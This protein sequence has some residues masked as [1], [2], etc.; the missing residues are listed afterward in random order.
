MHIQVFGSS[1]AGNCVRIYTDDNAG[2][3]IDAGIR[4]KDILAAGAPLANAS[5]L[6]THE[7]GDHSAHIKDL[8]DKYGCMIFATKETIEQVERT[9]SCKIAGRKKV[10]V[11]PATITYKRNGCRLLPFPVIHYPAVN[12]VGWIVGIGQETCL[13]MTD[14]GQ[15]PSMNFPRCDAYFIEANYTPDRLALNLYNSQ[16]DPRVADRTTSGFGH[17]GIVQAIEFMSQRASEPCIFLLGHRSA[18]NF[19]IDEALDLMPKDL[20]KK[21]YFVESGKTYS[22]MPF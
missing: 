17:I 21:T 22:T 10:L 11:E 3:F 4:P 2:V 20:L 12:P 14:I 1:S 9:H 13:Y 15:L 7:H 5:F 8:S 19:D 6:I 18:I 16:I